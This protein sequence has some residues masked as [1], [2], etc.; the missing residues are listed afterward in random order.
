M[1]Y[2][3]TCRKPM[4]PKL[5]ML[6]CRER[7]PLLIPMHFWSCD[8][9]ELTWEIEKSKLF[10]GTNFELNEQTKKVQLVWFS[11]EK[12]SLR[13][14]NSGTYSG[15]R[16]IFMM[17]LLLKAITYFCLKTSQRTAT[18]WEGTKHTSKINLR[19][20]LSHHLSSLVNHLYIYRGTSAL[21]LLTNNYNNYNIL[22]FLII[23]SGKAY[24]F[25][26]KQFFLV[27]HLT[28]I[29]CYFHILM[30]LF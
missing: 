21:V 26:D 5:R 12:I 30:V 10:H 4:N 15:P 11:I 22:L 14:S 29:A 24:L 8:Q 7:L 25:F 1:H 13:V 9:R 18:I 16:Q 23:D 2:I 17:K 28:A 3:S 6:I 19:G 27:P 20:S